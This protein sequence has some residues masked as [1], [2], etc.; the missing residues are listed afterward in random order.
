MEQKFKLD[1]SDG[2]R[3]HGVKNSVNDNADQAV[4]I[5]HGMAGHMYE[6]ALKFAADYLQDNYDV[7]RFNFYSAN[8]DARKLIDCDLSVHIADL[9]AMLDEYAPKY[10]K[11]YIIGHSYGGVVI[12]NVN[13][14]DNA[15]CVSLWDPSFALDS[16]GEWESVDAKGRKCYIMPMAFDVLINEQMREDIAK[17]TREYCLEAGEKFPLPIQV[18][19]GTRDLFGRYE[20]SY[21][22]RGNAKNVREYIEGAKHSFANLDHSKQL[23]EKTVAYFKAI[24]D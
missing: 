18:I 4:F 7:Y 1:T 16:F 3:I 9:Q 19:H 20:E 5:V 17:I 14:P 11:I 13:M 23:L 12:M 21:S 24:D 8:K 15:K 6:Y 10:K 22:S 2:F